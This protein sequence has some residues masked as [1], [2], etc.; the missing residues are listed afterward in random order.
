V[1]IGNRPLRVFEHKVEG[2]RVLAYW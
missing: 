1:E 2:G